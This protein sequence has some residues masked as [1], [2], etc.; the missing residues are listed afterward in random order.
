MLNT[1]KEFLLQKGS[2]RPQYASFYAKWVSDCYALLDQPLASNLSRD[3][4]KRFLSHMAKRHED[5]QVKQADTALRLYD[6]FLSSQQRDAFS[7]SP[8]R[9]G[10]WNLLEM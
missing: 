8:D 6:Y 7:S 9:E 10:E 1:Y 2:I 5:W 3:Q 4:K